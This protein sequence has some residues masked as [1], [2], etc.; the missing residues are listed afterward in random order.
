MNDKVSVIVPSRNEIFLNKTVEDLFRTATGEIEVI[1]ILDG[2]WPETL[3]DV[4]DKNQVH[5]L[6]WNFQQTIP[7]MIMNWSIFL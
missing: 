4:K 5:Y 3:P 1:V 7:L 6:H 2:Y